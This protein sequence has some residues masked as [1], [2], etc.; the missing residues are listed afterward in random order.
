MAPVGR[1]PLGYKWEEGRWIHVV[2]G[3]PL[4]QETYRAELR[5]RQREL[6]KR[7][8]RDENTGT[9]ARR[10]MRT[11]NDAEARA[12]ARPHRPRQL[13]LLGWVQKPARPNF[14]QTLFGVRG[15]ATTMPGCESDGPV[16]DGRASSDPHVR[17]ACDSGNG[18]SK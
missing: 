5:R 17:V 10:R 4:S 3:E 15:T 8:Y 1:P 11:L 13:T 7:R 9:R 14:I 16:I 18:N 12:A 2:T 6:E